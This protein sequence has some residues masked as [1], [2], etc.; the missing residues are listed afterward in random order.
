MTNIDY[1]NSW[2][3][4]AKLKEIEKKNHWGSCGC[5]NSQ[6]YLWLLKISD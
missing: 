6:V 4:Q 5:F 2:K 1:Y 3:A